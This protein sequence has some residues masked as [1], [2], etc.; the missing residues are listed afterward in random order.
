MERYESL[1]VVGEGSYG[2]VLRCRHKESGQTVAVKKFLES[3][4]DPTVKKI[5]LRE[6][7]MLKKLR[8]ENLVNLIEFFRRKRRLYLVFEYVDHTI[9]DELE[10]T[11]AGLDEETARAHIFQV[12]RGIAF[13]H[14][15][16][17]IHRDIKP[18]NVLV[19]RLGV[20][21]LCDFGFA[22]LLAGP[23]E[24]CTDYVATRWY[25]APELLV[26]DTKYGRE[27]DV[28]ASGCL[29]SE[30]LTG[31]PLFPGESDI[32][33][34][35]HIIQTLGELSTSHRHLVERNPML[36]GLRLPEAASTP[37]A[38]S[39]PNWSPRAHAFVSVCLCLEPSA[40][41]SA[42]ELLN[43]DFF[44][45]DCFP[46]TF[47]PILKQRVQQ[48][49]SN[50]FLLGLSG[51][52]GSSTADR[53]GRGRKFPG[54]ASPESVYGRSIAR[55]QPQPPP[56]TRS[57]NPVRASPMKQ[58]QPSTPEG[59]SVFASRPVVSFASLT[60]SHRGGPSA[61]NT[62][63]FNNINN[64]FNSGEDVPP[65]STT[66]ATTTTSTSSRLI[67]PLRDHN[68]VT[69]SPT[70]TTSTANNNTFNTN[71]N[72][73]NSNNNS[74]IALTLHITGTTNTSSPSRNRGVEK[75]RK[76]PA[77]LWG[78]PLKPRG[79]GLC[80]QGQG[81]GQHWDDDDNLTSDGPSSF[82]SGSRYLTTDHGRSIDAPRPIDASRHPYTI[83]LDR[84]K[85]LVGRDSSSL[86]EAAAR[87]IFGREFGR[88][89]LKEIKENSRERERRPR[90]EITGWARP[91]LLNND[92]SLPNVPGVSS[93]SVSNAQISPKK[94]PLE[95][96]LGGGKSRRG[97][98]TMPA[99][100]SVQRGSPNSLSR[101]VESTP[102]T[103]PLANLPYV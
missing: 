11:E 44:M 93:P 22:R 41:P 74:T 78:V 88:D 71:N 83:S 47:L 9:L 33:Q 17:I 49:F 87:D 56:A 38:S 59:Q 96:G 69:F 62:G 32:D 53:K 16:Q 7:R 85:E 66:T 70:T 1:G 6:V 13:C 75:S 73:N 5:A 77:S 12:L 64:S 94:Y 72:A 55:P 39:F 34:L 42:Q 103:S 25:R 43:H 45:H 31:E 65:P 97:G 57:E 92:L 46:E 18:E 89:P 86:R 84:T 26:G 81:Q 36:A 21:K 91:R 100:S 10:A 15:N 80:I 20:V 76:S 3:E 54:G 98:L 50:N 29:L 95:G 35:F 82:L 58:C 52:R 67:P 90:L 27:V 51:R 40:R 23:G 19:S 68:S 2:L 101:S 4:D 60:P 61:A 63:T 102:P 48:E 14:Q 8:H 24:S 99:L 28:W 37:L 79:H 30:M